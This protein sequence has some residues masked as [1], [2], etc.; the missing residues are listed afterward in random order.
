MIITTFIFIL[1]RVNLTCDSGLNEW[2]GLCS[3]ST[4]ELVFKTMIITIFMIRCLSWTILKLRVF[5]RDI[6][7]TKIINIVSGDCHIY[8]SCFENTEIHFKISHKRFIF[9]FMSLFLFFFNE[10][11]FCLHCLRPF[12]LR[13][14]TKYYLQ[15]ITFR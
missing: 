4:P 15:Q 2:L 3:E 8:I 7:G 1:T 14:I 5:Y 13:T 6:L 9:I 10:I 11:Y 12:Y